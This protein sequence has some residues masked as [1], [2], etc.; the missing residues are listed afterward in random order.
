MQGFMA[1]N[2]KLLKEIN[3]IKAKKQMVLSIKS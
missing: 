2:I 3:L 1:N